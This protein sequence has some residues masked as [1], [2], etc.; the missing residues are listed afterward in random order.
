MLD[1]LK[2]LKLCIGYDIGGKKFDYLPSC[3]VQQAKATP[4]YETLPGWEQ[5]T[6]GARDWKQLP[7]EAVTYIRRI[8]ELTRC[9]LSL[10][11]TSPAREEPILIADPF[12]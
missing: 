8:E 6:R 1:G 3:T 2:E 4:V 5:S 12:A 7:K 9:P 11:S 10:L